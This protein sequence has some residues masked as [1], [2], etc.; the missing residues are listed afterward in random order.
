MLIAT[1]LKGKSFR[2]L[3]EAWGEPVGTLLSARAAR[4]KPCA[5]YW[6]KRNR[7]VPQMIQQR[8]P[9]THP[10]KGEN[11]M[12]EV[13]KNMDKM[14]K[15]AKYTLYGILESQERSCWDC[16]LAT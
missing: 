1:E 6:R 4:S 15:W 2:E 12:S 11:K 7:N 8:N 16:S 10:G 5:R 13:K 3:S 14:P 9:G